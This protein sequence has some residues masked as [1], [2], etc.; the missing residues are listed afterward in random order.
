MLV[1]GLE[2][3]P[4]LDEPLRHLRV[5]M[6]GRPGEGHRASGG[7]IRSRN[8]G[9]EHQQRRKRQ[10]RIFFKASCSNVSLFVLIQHNIPIAPCRFLTTA[11]TS[12]YQ[13]HRINQSCTK[14]IQLLHYIVFRSS[15]HLISHSLLGPNP[16]PRSYQNLR[17]SK[18]VLIG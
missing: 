2:I 18:S 17:S 8:Q 7:S 15:T 5:A 6:S 4:G 13:W 10:Q 12:P 3:G 9:V 14:P 16:P 11:R 1:L